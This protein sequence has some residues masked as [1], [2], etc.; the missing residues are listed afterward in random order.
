MGMRNSPRFPGFT[1]PKAAVSGDRPAADFI[2][3]D[4]GFK[5]CVPGPWERQG[6]G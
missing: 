3:S 6:L 1:P 2:A 4:E 5:G